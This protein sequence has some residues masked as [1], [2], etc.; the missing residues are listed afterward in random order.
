[1]S[2]SL[3]KL[4]ILLREEISTVVEEALDKR[5]GAITSLDP[6]SI[7]G[8]ITADVLQYIQ[9]NTKVEPKFTSNPDVDVIDVTIAGKKCFTIT[10]MN[11]V[12][13]GKKLSVLEHKLTQKIERALN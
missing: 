6:T 2:E 13:V 7:K 3:D 10:V 9:Q 1:M 12:G 5:I 4:R 11:S 8:A